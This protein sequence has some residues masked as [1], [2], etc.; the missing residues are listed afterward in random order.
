APVAY[1]ISACMREVFERGTSLSNFA[2]VRNGMKTGDNDRFLRLWWEVG[3]CKVAIRTKN[4]IEAQQSKA[5]W[6]PYNKGGGYRKWYGNN[7]YVV[8]WENLGNEI[9]N[10]AKADGRNV[11]DYPLELK[12][13]PSLTWSLITSSKPSFR[14]KSGNLSD[15]AGMSLFADEEKIKRYLGFCNSPIALD[16]LKLI[17][18]TLNFQAGDIARIPIIDDVNTDTNFIVGVDQNIKASQLDWD[19]F[20]NSWD[21]SIFPLMNIKFQHTKLQVSY[22]KLRSYW[23]E[24]TLKMRS[25]EE[26]NNRIFIKAYGLQGELIPEV[27][28][29][30]ITLSCNPYYRYGKEE[31]LIESDKHELNEKN[32]NNSFALLIQKEF[33]INEEL[34]KRLLIDTMK[35]FVSYAV[36]CM[37][38]RYSLDKPGLV[39]ANA[40]NE[41]FDPTEYKTFPADDDGIVP[42][43]D[44]DWFA[45][46]ATPRLA[47]FIKTVFGVETF[48]EN[49][50]W[51]AESFEPKKGETPVETIRRYFSTQFFKNHMQMYKKRPIYWLFSSGKQRAF[52]CLVYLH[53]YNESTLAR[54]RAQYVT[55]LQG[56]LNARI[57]HLRRETDSAGSTAAKTKLR[58]EVEMLAKKQTELAKFDEELRHYAD[59]RI[60]INLDDGVRVNY[61]KF[62]T[63]LAET[64]AITGGTDE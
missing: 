24:M 48:D 28:L 5:K 22:Q 7:D 3:Y 13:V 19:S 43:C 17:A 63:L 16:I 39:Y 10:S 53:R 1:W 4:F 54:M 37:M 38:G 50:A 64:K 36:G 51:I 44:M 56:K 49:L 58:K 40:G 9:F 62:G 8:N 15:I 31:P 20:E 6:F 18:P 42:V 46:D 25:L 59:Q 60:K 26:N 23:L 2:I 57:E 11:Q 34:E 61:G 12:F 47:E 45:D 29:K 33:P 52:E 21:F 55:P 35:E 27:S 14:F 41:G 32:S 30:D